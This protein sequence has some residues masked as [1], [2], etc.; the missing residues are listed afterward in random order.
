MS[1]RLPT[2]RPGILIARL[3]S[4]W[5]AWVSSFFN[6]CLWVGF[7]TRFTQ[8]GRNCR[9]ETVGHTGKVFG[10]RGSAYEYGGEEQKMLVFTSGRLTEVNQMYGPNGWAQGDPTSLGP[11]AMYGGGFNLR[12]YLFQ[13][14]ISLNVRIQWHDQDGTELYDS[15]S[16][17]GQITDVDVWIPSGTT[18]IT[19]TITGTAK[20]AIVDLQ[21]AYKIAA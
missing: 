21:A 5:P 3:T 9:I 10:H 20:G 4:R 8:D 1:R 11:Y 7:V 6:G 17:N 12:I 13:S 14:H 2:V 15:G 18:S 19:G 16:F